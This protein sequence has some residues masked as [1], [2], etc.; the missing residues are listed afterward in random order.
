VSARA[1]ALLLLLAA[2]TAQAQRRPGPTKPLAAPSGWSIEAPARLVLGKDGP[3]A[4]RYRLPADARAH[5]ISNIG[6]LGEPRQVQP[7][8]WQV[9]FNPPSQKY[10]QVALLVLRDDEDESSFVW[11]QLPLH[12]VAT[13]EL[14]SDP[15]VQVEVQVAGVAFGPTRTDKHGRAAVSVVV[16]PGVAEAIS[17]ASDALGNQRHQSIPIA[18]PEFQR[19]LSLCAPGGAPGFWV[20]AID[21][22]GAAD[23]DAKLEAEVAPL[24]VRAIA[25]RAPG[26][27]RVG[28]RIPDQLRAGDIVRVA[29]RVAGKPKFVSSCELR[30]P[31]E[32]PERLDM[33]LSRAVFAAG[34]A[35]PIVVKITPRY[36][37][38]R[39][40]EATD[41]RFEATLGKLSQTRVRSSSQVELTWEVPS[42]FGGRSQASLRVRA[43]DVIATRSIA[44]EAGPP[45]ALELIAEDEQLPADGASSTKLT[46][47]ARDA[48]G[49]PVRVARLRASARGQVSEFRATGPGKFE[50]N[51]RAPDE[52]TS[53]DPVQVRELD[54]GM[55]ARHAI[56]LHRKR[57]PFALSLRAGYLTNF[58]KVSAPQL[59]LQFAYRLPFAREHIQ[60]ALEAGYFRSQ[61][62]T[63]SADSRDSVRTRVQ[64][65]PLALRVHYVLGFGALDLWPFVAAGVLFGSTELSAASTGNARTTS[66]I[67][68]F[69]AGG[70]GSLPLGAGR[71]LLELGYSYATFASGRARGNAGGFNAGLGYALE[72]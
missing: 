50:A 40:P 69:A 6:S 57:P 36:A 65:V 17:V 41:L 2:G 51:Y 43:G 12:G 71:A 64:G 3:T 31:L 54:S 29:A 20:L 53:E 15:E 44:L 48:H 9:T 5:L 33:T 28:L 11:T 49:N 39:E 70:G 22:K 32:R 16:P 66:S 19:L 61:D 63:L 4:I 72:L 59:T 60:I 38:A 45:S 14:R 42:N 35:E 25:A 56:R 34:E 55:V 27:Y 37:G 18:V 62:E 24:A 52:L 8:L 7:G 58:A 10:P 67:P 1:L 68:L 13:V 47:Q 46:L 30:V 21:T 23:S 26:V